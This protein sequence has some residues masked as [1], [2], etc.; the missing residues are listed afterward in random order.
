MQLAPL[1]EV[2]SQLNAAWSRSASVANDVRGIPVDSPP[3]KPTAS[4]FVARQGAAALAAFLV[5]TGG[6]LTA[7]YITERDHRGYRFGEFEYHARHSS[8]RNA[9][10][11]VRSPAENLAHVRAVFEPSITDLASLFG[12]SRQT[13][14]NW[15]GGQTI[16][17]Q[18]EHRLGRLA[19]AA[20]IIAAH[21]LAQKLSVLR[22][23]VSGGKSFFELVRDG[24]DPETV[25]HVLVSTLQR[26]LDQRKRLDARLANRAR[27]R[28][29]L[30]DVG[31]PHLDENT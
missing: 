26:E 27:K 23:M 14:Y 15:Q 4:M 22:R 30:D 9:Q 24:S 29:D 21:G 28:V 1:G 13:I 6:L 3:K 12:V 8:V 31:A 2:R 25:A 18:N 5:G 17:Q 16:A 19:C 10:I 7:S 20:D 11:D